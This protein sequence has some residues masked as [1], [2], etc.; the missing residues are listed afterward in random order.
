[1]SLSGLCAAGRAADD[2]DS[3]CARRAQFQ[4]Y[5]NFPFASLQRLYSRSTRFDYNCTQAPASCLLPTLHWKGNARLLD[6]FEHRAALCGAA[7]GLHA[8]HASDR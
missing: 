6:L 1:M 4:L 2:D 7:D 5:V 3:E 8:L